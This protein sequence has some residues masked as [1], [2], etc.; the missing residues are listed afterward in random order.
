[1]ISS[2]LQTKFWVKMNMYYDLH[3]KM[4]QIQGLTEYLTKPD[5]R[6]FDTGYLDLPDFRKIHKQGFCRFLISGPKERGGRISDILTIRPIPIAIIALILIACSVR[7]FLIYVPIIYILE[8]P[9][10]YSFTCS[11]VLPFVSKGIY[12]LFCINHVLLVTGILL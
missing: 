10:F 12:Y 8:F 4:T 6:S 7:I 9:A 1:M 5:I 11:C 2:G 3:K